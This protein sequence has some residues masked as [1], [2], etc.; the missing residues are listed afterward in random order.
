M[1]GRVTQDVAEM[2]KKRVS[3]SCFLIAA[4]GQFAGYNNINLLSE[5]TTM[6]D[7]LRYAGFDPPEAELIVED[8]YN[9]L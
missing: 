7:E 3:E 4:G 1:N 9:R 8:F 2:F 5:A 6:V